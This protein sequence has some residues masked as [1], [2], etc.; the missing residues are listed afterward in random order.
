M[1]RA[2]VLILPLALL[3]AGALQFLAGAGYAQ[4]LGAS[5]SERYFRVEA[6]PG[7]TRGGRPILYGYVYNDYGLLA[8][9]VRL[10][11]ESVDASGRTTDRTT[12]FVDGNIPAFSR[13]YF[14]MPAPAAAANYRVTVAS[15]FFRQGG[16][17]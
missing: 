13:S 9:N 5:P 4:N 10:T 17:A 6:H 12:G 16:G 14:E 15:F 8:I 11:A 7:P 1:K 2:A 3:V